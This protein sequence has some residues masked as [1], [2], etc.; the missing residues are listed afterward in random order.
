MRETLKRINTGVWLAAATMV[1]AY[2]MGRYIGSDS[3]A[4]GGLRQQDAFMGRQINSI[5]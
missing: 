1:L 4:V 5:R 3:A 2:C